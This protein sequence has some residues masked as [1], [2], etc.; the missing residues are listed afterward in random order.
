M[1]QPLPPDGSLTVRVT[2]LAGTIGSNFVNGPTRAGLQPWSKAG[3]I[4]A[5]ST[6][7]GSAYA[8]M[9]VTGGH[10]VRMQYDY[11]HDTA[12]LPGGVSAVSPRWLRLVRSGDTLT[13][14]DSADG[15]H[16][17]RA[18][19]SG[20]AGLP[21]TAQAGLFVASPAGGDRRRIA[22][23]PWPRRPSTRSAG[24][25][26]GPAAA[27]AANRSAAGT[28]YRPL[29]GRFRPAGDGLTVSGS[30]DIAP[31]GPGRRASANRPSMAW[32]ACSR[33]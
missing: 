22:S 21:S 26:R 12:G 8:A 2:S 31:A 1:H 4:V 16:W 19:P 3:I 15:T 30:G 29:P 25:A 13:G 9:M 23:P 18:A 27:G 28:G 7:P 17:T 24:P 5:A 14:Y 10:G 11:T 33:R 20:L 32:P 6:R